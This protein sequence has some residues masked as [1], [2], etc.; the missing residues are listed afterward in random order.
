MNNFYP[1][2]LLAV[3]KQRV[4][5]EVADAQ[6]FRKPQRVSFTKILLGT[7][8]TWMIAGG[9]KLQSLNAEPLQV[10]Q[11]KFSHNKAGKTGS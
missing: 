5:R 3:A 4:Q 10:N 6:L 1:E 7:L 11:L 9:E 8:G 2:D